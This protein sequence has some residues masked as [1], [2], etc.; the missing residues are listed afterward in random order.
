MVG[1][2]L[3]ASKVSLGAVLA[4]FLAVAAVYVEYRKRI[5]SKIMLVTPATTVA[6]GRV[7]KPSETID[8]KAAPETQSLTVAEE[9]HF[10]ES[11]GLA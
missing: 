6:A 3:M 4:S 1:V 2:V 10:Y 9:T 5:I 8:E 7:K 11:R